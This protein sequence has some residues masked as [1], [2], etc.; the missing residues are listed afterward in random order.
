[1]ALAAEIGGSTSTKGE[2][3]L[4]R[5]MHNMETCIAACQEAIIACQNCAA[6]DIRA[7]TSLCALINLD[8]AD[9]CAATMNAIARRSIH[10]GDFCAICAHICRA[11]ATACAAHAEVH[12]HCARCMAACEKCAVECAKHAKERHI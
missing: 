12:E 11:C 9:I 7:G 1:M 8:C 10:H 6:Q 4:D 2:I 5:E 3:M